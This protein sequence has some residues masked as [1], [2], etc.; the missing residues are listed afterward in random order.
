MADVTEQKKRGIELIEELKNH[1]L[2][3]ISRDPRGA[4]G[5]EGLQNV[6]IERLAGLEI[7]LDRPPKKKQEHWLTWTIVQRLVAD[8]IIE[9]VQYRRTTYRLS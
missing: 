7:P 6:E 9:P 8:G 1:V 4:R 2:N 3:I 5:A